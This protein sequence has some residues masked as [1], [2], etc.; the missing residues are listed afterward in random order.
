MIAWRTAAEWAELGL[1]G[2]PSTPSA[3]I[4]RAT[5][6][7]WQRRERAG[8]G[9]GFE[10]HYTS[11]PEVALTAYLVGNRP[12]KVEVASPA[13]DSELLWQ[14]YDDLPSTHKDE[15]ERRLAA[16]QAVEALTDRGIG[17]VKAVAHVAAEIGANEATIRRWLSAIKGAHRSDRL[18]I[19]APKWTGGG[20]AAECPEEAW[21][22]IKAD[23][24]RKSKPSFSGCYER[25]CRVAAE[26]GWT[27]PS[28]RTML[29]RIEREIPTPV[30]LFEREGREALARAYPA[31]Q[32]DHSTFHA[33]EAV[34]A[35]GHKFDVFCKWPDGTIGRPIGLFWQDIRS[36]KCLAYRIDRTETADAVRL[37]F[38]DL[39]DEYGVP[40][41]VFLDNG[42]AFSSK[43]ITGQMEFRH[44]FKRTKEEPLG[45]LTQLGIEVTWA[46]PYH[47][48]A[49]P[50]ERMFRD[51]CD[52]V[53]KHPAFE[54]AYTGNNP[55]AKPENYGSRAVP[56]EEFL[57]ILDQEI[58]YHNA[59]PGRR[60]PVCNG[61]L[62]FDQAFEESY[63][64]APIRQITEAQR[65]LWLLAA[66]NV[67]ASRVDG[68]IN[69]MGNR[70]WSD[71]MSVLM[72]KR[73]TIRFDPDQL[74]AG[75]HVYQ[76]DGRYVGFVECVMAA[77]FADTEA[78]RAHAHARKSWT[79]HWK[80]IAEAE[81]RM[82]AAEV[83]AR[84][85]APDAPEPAPETKVVRPVFG[86]LAMKPAPAASYL[87]DDDEDEFAEGFSRNVRA[88][89]QK[90]LKE[91][92]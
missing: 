4:R 84:L 53:S 67:S 71:R 68:A 36:A 28:E 40:D 62:S 57:R 37:S 77:G 89:H 48:Q 83:A 5:R 58:V 29:R 43:W 6:E 22:L 7:N 35:D 44:R 39:V 74:H 45:I 81:K 1:P 3:L 21:D 85:P 76:R 16:I 72:G 34:N 46:T 24:L 18:P 70:Y 17:R 61:V 26:R 82:T 51:F 59:K 56:I 79:K 30:M 47:G 50:I 87:S 80:G 55:T 27:L 25:L 60:T 42:R 52:R 75:I 15:A 49:K 64:Q 20:K 8:R 65:R 38:G 78:A 19:L 54:G 12:A 31:Q 10:Y 73:L 41:R 91:Q 13:D 33:L 90:F 63:R 66:E 32:R 88:L 2:L 14:R 9:G 11:L 86:N 69:F 92:L 23:Y